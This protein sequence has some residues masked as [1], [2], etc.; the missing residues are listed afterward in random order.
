MDDLVRVCIDS[1]EVT[2]LA[3][4]FR[5]YKAQGRYENILACEDIVVAY[6]YGL[7]IWKGER[8]L[9][10][11]RDRAYSFAAI[12]P[13]MGVVAVEEEGVVD[14]Y[15]SAYRKVQ[16]SKA[17]SGSFRYVGTVANT[18]VMVWSSG[19]ELLG[20]VLQQRDRDDVRLGAF[21]SSSFLPIPEAGAL[22]MGGPLGSVVVWEVTSHRCVRIPIPVRHS[23]VGLHWSAQ[24]RTLYAGAKNGKVFALQF[25]GTADLW[26]QGEL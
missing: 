5:E 13:D 26:G 7:S 11:Y 1:G 14:V 4:G 9:L 19:R 18:I 17:P 12:L 20:A 23:I 3:E 8:L 10:E 22:V 16:E 2:L 25:P 21:D 6:R 24:S 15:D